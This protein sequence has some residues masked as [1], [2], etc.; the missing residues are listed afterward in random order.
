MFA[1]ILKGTRGNGRVGKMSWGPER[2]GTGTGIPSVF[3]CRP[4]NPDPFPTSVSVPPP[5]YR[6]DLHN[7]VPVPSVSRPVVMCIPDFNP[8]RRPLVPI[9]S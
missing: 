6:P 1:E 3:R 7:L 8:S 2:I 9:K 5:V 4:R